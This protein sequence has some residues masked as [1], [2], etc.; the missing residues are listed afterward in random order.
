MLQAFLQ[1]FSG[2][3]VRAAVYI[4]AVL[5][6]LYL[7]LFMHLLQFPSVFPIYGDGP[8]YAALAD[9]L[10]YHGVF[11]ASPQAPFIPATFIMPVYPFLLALFKGAFGSY[12]FF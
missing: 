3:T 8:Y 12:T 11:S 5:V 6:L 4:G 9:N 7:P 1:F 10:L 2:H